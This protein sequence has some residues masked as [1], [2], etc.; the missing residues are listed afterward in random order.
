MTLYC[1]WVL[2][3]PDNI[4]LTTFNYSRAHRNFQEDTVSCPQLETLAQPQPNAQMHSLAL[5]NKKPVCA[6]HLLAAFP[7]CLLCLIKFEIWSDIKPVHPLILGTL[8]VYL[9]DNHQVLEWLCMYMLVFGL[10]IYVQQWFFSI[11][12]LF[13]CSFTLNCIAFDNG[14]LYLTRKQISDIMRFWSETMTKSKNKI[15]SE[16]NTFSPQ[17]T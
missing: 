3:L 8:V 15:Q 17:C 16:T 13:I 7:A 1:A 5:L 4:N 14:K 11:N 2:G 10:E 9:F 12:I 6:T